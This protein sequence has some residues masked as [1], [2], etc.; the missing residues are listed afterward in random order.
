M[1]RFYD[2]DFVIALVFEIEGED[3][4]AQ[5]VCISVEQLELL[6]EGARAFEKLDIAEEEVGR[7]DIERL[8]DLALAQRSDRAD[9]DR[10]TIP[11]YRRGHAPRIDVVTRQ[12]VERGFFVIGRDLRTSTAAALRINGPDRPSAGYALSAGTSPHRT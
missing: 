3:D 6:R 5:L 11:V 2:P 1:A 9:R 7:V 10:T 12:V 4:T 8:D